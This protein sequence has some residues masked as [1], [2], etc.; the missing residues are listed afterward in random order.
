[1]GEL[2]LTLQGYGSNGMLAVLAVLLVGY[3]GLS[4]FVAL[5]YKFCS[6]A[7]LPLFRWLVV[8]K[9]HKQSTEVFSEDEE[10]VF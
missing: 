3:W 1:M 9:S 4:L 7:F 8:A 2:M 10:I 5:K 6:L